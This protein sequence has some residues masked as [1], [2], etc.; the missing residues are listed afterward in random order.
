MRE[1]VAGADCPCLHAAP[2]S[3][4][5][6]QSRVRLQPQFGP[7]MWVPVM[8]RPGAPWIWQLWRLH[9]IPFAEQTDPNL[10]SLQGRGRREPKEGRW[11]ETERERERGTV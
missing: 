5:P 11:R 3:R 9:L 4:P 2:Q 10:Q 6:S 8:G 1:G 7:K